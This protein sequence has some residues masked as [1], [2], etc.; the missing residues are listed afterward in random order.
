MIERD[1]ISPIPK[2]W[3]EIHQSLLKYWD[4]ELQQRVS[5]PPIPLILAGWNFSED[6]EKRLRWTQTL[7]WAKE[8]KCEHLL[9]ELSNDEKYFG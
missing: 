2:V 5:K 3:H 1:Y 4:L 6:W 8:N 7:N 9:I